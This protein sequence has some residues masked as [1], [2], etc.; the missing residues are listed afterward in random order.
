MA[1][2]AVTTATASNALRVTAMIRPVASAR[3]D[4][5]RLMVRTRSD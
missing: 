2:M 1:G 5:A 3:C 4:E